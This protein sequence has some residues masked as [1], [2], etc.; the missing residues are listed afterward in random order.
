M[1]FRTKILLLTFSCLIA[2]SFLFL[3]IVFWQRERL[4]DHMRNQIQAQSYAQCERIA[5]DGYLMIQVQHERIKKDVF[6][7]LNVARH[8]LRAHGTVTFAPESVS[9]NAA[10]QVTKQKQAVSLPKM[11]V[12]KQW[13]GNNTS[14][15]AASLVVDE[16]KSLVGGSCTI[17]QRM[18]EAGDMLRV[19]TNVENAEHARAVGTFIP[20]LEPDGNPNPVI[21]TVLKGETYLGRALVVKDWCISAYE[22]ILDA[23]KQIVGLLYV[24]VK[25]DE[26]PELRQ[27]L[28]DVVVGKTGYVYVLGG[29]GE[30][31]GRF[32]VA[33]QGKSD[34]EQ[35]LDVKDAD[36]RTFVQTLLQDALAAKRGDTVIVRYPV[37]KSGE[38]TTHYRDVAATYFEPWDWIICAEMNEDDEQE[39]LNH[40]ASALN[41][42]ALWAIIAAVGG[43]GLCTIAVTLFLRPIT[44]ALHETARVLQSLAA[45]DYTQ[46]LKI[47]TRDE[48]GTM[49]TAVN[50]TVAAVGQAMQDLKNAADREQ[51]LQSQQAVQEQH[52]AEER[53]QRELEEARRE[54]DRVQAERQQ[55]EEEANRQR[56]RAAAE[57]TAAET[58]RQKVDHLLDVVRA[59]A[60]GDLT[61]EVRVEGDEPV[62]ELAAEIRK[63]LQDLAVVIGQVTDSATRFHEGAGVLANGSRDLAQGAQAQSA[64]VQE[65]TASIEELAHSIE[66]VKENANEANRVASQANQLAQEGDSAVQK[67]TESMQQIRTSSQR[68]AEI[69][70]V[71]SDIASQTNLLALNAAIEAA[72]AGEHGMGFAVV[73]DEVRKLAERSNV[74]AREIS[75]LIQDSTR[76]VEEG[77][78]L[79]EQTAKALKRI[80]EAAETTAA[81]IAQIATV[82][83]QQAASAREVSTS[84]Q[85]VCPGDRRDGRQQRYDGL[86]KCRTR[87][88]RRPTSRSGRTLQDRSDDVIP[89][90]S[91]IRSRIKGSFSSAPF[92]ASDHLRGSEKAAIAVRHRSDSRAATTDGCNA[93]ARGA[94]TGAGRAR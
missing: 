84:I 56:Q 49:A 73:A 37:R 44:T 60:Q 46:R 65:M 41:R 24:G 61:R 39:T 78:Q 43:L 31:K 2:T 66:T 20:A 12:G 50:T 51:Q 58:M 21:S 70:Q 45:G 9:W 47:R 71:I 54:R 42:L 69:I 28:R 5:K 16:V 34:G 87:K 23:K 27:G 19:C 11:M 3:A 64:S 55:Q 81:K 8:V 59:A 91:L 53:R 67:S 93:G 13:L 88:I 82:T 4:S 77:G 22:P 76:Q 63:M 75:T 26:V 1:N 89:R 14:M 86:P 6:A 85:S 74:A 25:Q 72:R 94:T 57:R 38:S 35:L 10:N 29:S 83:V 62:D 32:I 40:T 33:P 48:I 30:Q 18:N 92:T 90:R 17:F 79:S 36:G 52:E 80:I 15:A 7:S 68:I